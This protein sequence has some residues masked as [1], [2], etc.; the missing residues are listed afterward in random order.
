MIPERFRGA[1]QRVSIASDGG[2]PYEPAMVVWVQAGAAFADLR[3][4]RPTEHDADTAEM[5]PMSFAGVTRWEDPCLRWE[6]HLDLAVASASADDAGDAA[7]VGEV[8]WDGG[9]LVESGSSVR[10][11][12]LVRYVEVWRRLA[13]SDGRTLALEL[14]DG[15]G[16]LVQTGD[17]AVT[18]VDDRPTGGVYR[19]AYRIRRSG[20]WQV[21]LSLGDDAAAIAAPPA[22]VQPLTTGG[23]LPL[24]GRR[25]RVVEAVPAPLA[26]TR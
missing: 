17:H 21:S 3:V 4:P 24:A 16:C 10:D 7:D 25:W 23:S 22:D 12:R 18:V 2:L 11:G 8:S 6:H 5:V 13:G 9:D 19:A 15:L 26:L 14:L 1:W 20:E